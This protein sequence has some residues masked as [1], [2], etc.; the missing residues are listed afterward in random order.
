ME[1]VE[2]LKIDDKGDVL[3][4]FGNNPAYHIISHPDKTGMAVKVGDVIKYEPIGANFG[5]FIEIV[6]S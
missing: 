3:Y 6:K 4:F 1:T 5:W 2:V